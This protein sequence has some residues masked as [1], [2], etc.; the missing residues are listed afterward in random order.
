MAFGKN[1]EKEFVGVFCICY[2]RYHESPNGHSVSHKSRNG[3]VQCLWHGR[4]G[5]CR[6][7][8]I[9]TCRGD[10]PGKKS[11]GYTR[12][13]KSRDGTIALDVFSQE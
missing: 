12:G 4:G 3:Y 7:R 10:T 6:R 5:L 8:P 11:W 2:S 1:Y 13:K 9:Y